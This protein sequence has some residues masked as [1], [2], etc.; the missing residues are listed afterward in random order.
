MRRGAWNVESGPVGMTLSQDYSFNEQDLQQSANN[1]QSQK[2]PATKTTDNFQAD[3]IVCKPLSRDM[4]INESP[5]T[6]VPVEA[7]SKEAPAVSC[8]NA[9]KVKVKQTFIESSSIP[10]LTM[11]ENNEK[12]DNSWQTVRRNK[13]KQNYRY[14]GERGKAESIT[15]SFKAAAKKIPIFITNVHNDTLESDIIDYIKTKTQ[16]TV[17]LEKVNTK[18][19]LD[20]K[21]YKFFVSESK[22][23]MFLDD[24][25]WPEGI[26]FRRFVH[27]KHRKVDGVSADIGPQPTNYG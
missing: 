18:K 26:I 16:E 4:Q 8:E 6:N 2:S 14:L 12:E 15:S 25:I 24:K 19:V 11:Q 7:G 22:V 21:A 13:K 1:G 23:T 20:H 27:Y 17:F 5:I 3:V 10:K 9:K